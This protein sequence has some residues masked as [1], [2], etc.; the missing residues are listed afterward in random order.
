MEIKRDRY[1]ERLKR[2]RFK[3]GVKIITGLRRGGK[4]YLLFN[5]FRD[6]LLESGVP[7][8]N[9]I[10]IALDSV[11]NRHLRSAEALY[12]EVVSRIK[13]DSEYYVMI[14]EIQF[15]DDFVDF[16]NGLV[17]RK[18]VDLYITGSNSKFLS[19]DIVTEF[20]GR[21]SDI[22]VRPLSFSE[23]RDAVDMDDRTAWH[24]YLTYGGLP[25]SVELIDEDKV[26]YL[27]ELIKVV[28]MRDMIE[29]KRVRLPD[30]LDKVFDILSSAV[31]S[32]TNPNR[33]A[34]IMHNGKIDVDGNTVTNYISHLE[35]AFLFERSKRFDLKGNAYIDTPSKYYAVDL[36]IR[37]AKLGF[38]QNEY[39]H[40]M[41]NA[42][43]NELRYRG[44]SVDVG[45]IGIREYRMGKR[46][47]KQLEID[48][49]ANKGSDRIYI[50]S[51]YRMDEPTK[52]D[53]ELRPFLKINDGFRKIVLVG[54]D[55]PP[56]V[57]EKGIMMMNV[58]DF[59]KD[60]D[61]L[62]RI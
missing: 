58:I 59:M 3:G 18:N 8:D 7:E 5:I 24:T 48:F 30:V 19:S 38:R 16:V 60:P 27:T 15:A 1:L 46:D 14:D 2:L 33:I 35:D 36:G 54:D 22:N 43:Y 23:Y 40:L 31:G 37:N 51:A 28:Y 53:Q 62:E 42:I 49:V 61:S 52:R 47:Y 44:Y 10:A 17:G 4:S 13:D 55:V 6:Y 20:R 41:E 57:N 26:N 56:H 45:V 29:R 34:D 11:E 12:K 50:Q 21:G 32:L 9:I 39:N 25:E